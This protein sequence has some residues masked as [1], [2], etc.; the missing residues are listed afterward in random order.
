MD[1]LDPQEVI[2]RLC[3]LQSEVW[4]AVIDPL[5][6]ADGFCSQCRSQRPH[7]WDYQNTGE[8]LRYIET[9]VRSAIKRDQAAGRRYP[10]C[11]E[12][13]SDTPTKGN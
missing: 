8:A 4:R 11:L 9:A 7:A 12:Y 13:D 1:P 10:S 2:E 6:A 5:H 3:A